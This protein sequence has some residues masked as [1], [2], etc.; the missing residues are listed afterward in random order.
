M[1]LIEIRI[2]DI[3]DFKNVPVIEVYVKPGDEVAAEQALLLLESDKA[4][5]DVPAPTAGRITEFYLILGDKVSQGSLVALLETADAPAIIPPIHPASPAQI[6]HQ[7][8]VAQKAA[9]DEE[10]VVIGAGPGGYAAAFRAADLGAKVTL[11]EQYSRMGGVCLNVGCI[12]SK[13]LLHAASVISE[14]RAFAA[15]GINFGNPVID[16]NGLRATKN[17]VIERLTSGLASLARQRKVKMVQG[18]ARFTGPHSLEVDSIDGKQS[19]GFRQAIIA[20]GSKSVTLPFLPVDKRIIDS[21][22]ALALTDVP[23]RLL[24]IGGGIIGLEMATIYAALGSRITIVELAEQLVPGAD[25][26]I[27]APLQKR[28]DSVSE[29]ILLSS[30]V[31]AVVATEDG[32]MARFETPAGI[33]E[34]I[35]DRILVAVG[36]Q[37]N[38][39]LLNVCAAGVDVQPNGF[40]NVNDEMRTNIRHIFAIGDVVGQPMLAHKATHEG[41]LAAEIACGHKTAFAARVIPSVAYTDPEIAWVGLTEFQAEAS[42]IAYEKGVFPWAASG[43][44]LSLGR[45]D[46]LTK[47]LFDPISRRLIGAGIVGP[48]AGDLIG[49][50]T[51]AIEM[52]ADAADIALTIH[53]HPTLS[54]TLGL[55]AEMFEG[56]ITD[57]WVGKRRGEHT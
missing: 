26:D 55:A 17:S 48:H 1:S 23:P 14:T 40:I 44:S 25:K 46:G 6:I 4:A 11:I 51:L 8:A 53:P 21:T 20:A 33:R 18:R 42:S 3:G 35:F 9:G 50:A 56:S 5:L 10:I 47:L 27:V 34:A 24:I 57:L 49:E 15:H 28:L 22:G 54:E 36:R 7:P 13:T 19:I 31:T 12:P 30:K 45:S 39:H 29:Q 52:G 32:L 16:L 37:P 38:G 43:R 2:P 41:H